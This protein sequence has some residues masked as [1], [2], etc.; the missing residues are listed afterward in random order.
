MHG[1]HISEQCISKWS[2]FCPTGSQMQMQSSCLMWTLYKT[3]EKLTGRNNWFPQGMLDVA[4]LAAN[5]SQLKITLEVTCFP[6]HIKSNIVPKIPQQI[7][8][9]KRPWAMRSSAHLLHRHVKL[10]PWGVL[11]RR[12]HFTWTASSSSSA[13]PSLCRF[14]HLNLLSFAFCKRSAPTQTFIKYY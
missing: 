1:I 5:T 7:K 6:L 4:I 12:A 14:L 3:D 10:N 2:K 8:A 13:L 9:R 11:L